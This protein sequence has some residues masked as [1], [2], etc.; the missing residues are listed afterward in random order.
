MTQ[1]RSGRITKIAGPLIVAQGIPNA[2]LYDVVRVGDEKL[3]GEIIEIRGD[4]AWI[5]VYEDTSGLVTGQPVISTYEPLS[6]TLGPGLLTSI[7][8]GIQRPLAQIAKESQGAFIARG[9]NV[10]AID[11][12]KKWDFEPRAKVGQYVSAGDI[13]GV[14]QETSMIEHR[15]LVPPKVQGKITTLQKGSYTAHSTIAEILTDDN[16]KISVPLSQKWPIREPRP[17]N[18]KK[19]PI[20][21]LFAGQRTIDTFFPVMMGGAAIIPG[22]FGSGKT[23]TQQQLAKWAN[24]DIIVYIGCGERGNEMTDVLVEF[25]HL[26][27]PKSGNPLMD[28]TILIANTSNMP[29]AAR[30]ASV[31]TGITLA[32][33]YRDQGYN[34]ALMADSTSRWAEAMREM[35]GRLEEMPGE[36]GYP[37]YL[38]SRIAEFYERAGYVE[39]LGNDTKRYGS[40]TIIGAVSPPGGD[41][42]EPVSQASLGVSKAFWGLDASLAYAR[43]YPAINWLSSYTLYQDEVDEYNANHIDSNFPDYRREAIEILQK[44]AELLEIIRIVGMDSLSAQEKI[45]LDTAK[46]LREDYL[47]QDAFDD[48]DSFA[49]RNKMLAMLQIILTFHHE[50][51][52]ISREIEDV[53]IEV[54]FDHPTK[55]LMG[56]MKYI[57]ESDLAKIQTAIKELPK[58]MRQYISKQTP[59]TQSGDSVHKMVNNLDMDRE[60]IV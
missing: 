57:P 27:D 38:S 26:K 60:E 56:S 51:M 36:G 52:A 6:L 53:E 35:S 3:T 20:Q 42:S 25:P 4:Q 12:Q 7:Y 50:A 34:V 10:A 37:A 45:T 48:T 23:V 30:E 46:S 29:I 32:E 47:Q 14:V 55:E 9:V 44:E 21:P 54:L 59:G 2:A 1:K 43:H 58:K 33:Y 18:Q 16:Q 17:V 8:D 28:R 11:E 22:P 49:S 19:R 15:V 41:L 39:C 31:Y 5:Q 24:V 40:V 13:L